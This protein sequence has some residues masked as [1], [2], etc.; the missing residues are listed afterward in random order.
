MYACC[1]PREFNRANSVQL[2]GSQF[3]EVSMDLV[4]YHS[5]R[6]SS[7]VVLEGPFLIHHS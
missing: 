2:L 5:S 3:Q 4:L 7:S 6:L 1:T